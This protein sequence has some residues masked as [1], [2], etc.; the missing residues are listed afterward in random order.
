M[1]SIVA[2]SLALVLGCSGS[3]AVTPDAMGDTSADSHGS[4]DWGASPDHGEPPTDLGPA[5]VPPEDVAEPLPDTGPVEVQ[6]D[7]NFDCPPSLAYCDAV[8]HICVACLT[9]L[10]CGED[11]LCSA[12]V[13]VNKPCEPGST[14]C[15]NDV[16]KTCNPAGTGWEITDCAPMMCV[17]GA[18]V[19]CDAGETRC[20]SG[21]VEV[22]SED[23]THF[24]PGEICEGACL[25]GACHL[26]EPES[27]GCEGDV[28]V[29]CDETGDAWAPVEDCQTAL[30]GN[31]CKLGECVSLCDDNVKLST[32]VGCD[33]WAVDLDQIDDEQYDTDN[34]PYAVVVS[35]V[36]PDYPA[37]VIITDDQGALD[38]GLGQVFTQEVPPGELRIFDLPP[39][40]VDKTVKDKLAWHITSTIPIIAYQFNP[41]ENVEVFSNDASMLIP[42][43]SLGKRHVVL[44]WR[45]RRGGLRAFFTIVGVSDE[46][47]TVTVKPTAPTL[48]GAG[49]TSMLPGS[50]HS[51]TLEAFEVLNIESDA[52]NAELTGTVIESDQPVAVFVGTICSNIPDTTTCQDGQC[53]HQPG[54]SCAGPEDCPVT[55]CCDHLEEQLPPLAAWGKSYLATKSFE[56]GAELDLYRLVASEPDTTITLT[57]AVTQVPVLG[58]GEFFDFEAQGHFRI[59]ADKPILA[60]WFLASENAPAPTNDTCTGDFMG[61]P[62]CEWHSTQGKIRSCEADV[63]CPNIPMPGDAGIGDPAFTLL[64]PSE[65]FRS[66]YLF[67]V[68]NKY[69]LDYG[70][71]VAFANAQVTLDG[72]LLD[73]AD[74]EPVGNS[75]YV[76]WRLPLAD[77]VHALSADQPIGAYIYGYD[78]YVSYGYPAGA[79][80]V[81]IN[82]GGI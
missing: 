29:S 13:C 39:R 53:L 25:E 63:H 7:T 46:L 69:E 8:R 15:K 35:N 52:T 60:G 50:E 19:G 81:V 61:L 16:L 64:V 42:T 1:R 70:T 75:G 32:N 36:N 48:A 27:L 54:W 57:P 45:E 2:L 82:P 30:T 21:V 66:D 34:A 43:N 26:C 51:F 24:I 31:V 33:Y 68:P 80:V 22:C 3:D 47:T 28:V 40:N 44:T 49:V 59:E 10:H 79:N 76:T 55:C 6:C 71:I 72:E 5:D 37:Q 12:G 23:G 62:V 11:E 77:G 9:D 41:L 73:P 74:A 78:E 17:D 58:A 14:K 65:Q 18:C 4:F 20:Q 56:R 67:L 38:P